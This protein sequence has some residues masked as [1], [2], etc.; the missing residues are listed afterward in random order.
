M[1]LPPSSSSISDYP[2][3]GMFHHR[4]APA[5]IDVIPIQTTLW[6]R[7]EPTNAYD[8]NAVKVVI[9][10]AETP[11]TC[12]LLLQ[13]KLSGFGVGL[14]EYLS[15]EEWM[16]GYIPRGLAAVLRETGRVK[17]EGDVQG[18]F[19][20]NFTGKPLVRI[21]DEEPKVKLIPEAEDA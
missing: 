3:V 5:I 18:E 1:P 20:V 6:L 8:V 19:G 21:L 11:D 7:A 4:P 9:K 2:I 16:L 12:H 14:E 13:D 17:T 10:S 15:Q